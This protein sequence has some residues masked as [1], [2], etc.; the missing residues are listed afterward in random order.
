MS[1][2]RKNRLSDG[3]KRKGEG[4]GGRESYLSKTPCP[5]FSFPESKDEHLYLPMISVQEYDVREG[6]AGGIQN[7]SA[8]GDAAPRQLS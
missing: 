7:P 6:N 5:F 4:E 1:R 2:L 8:C 3:D